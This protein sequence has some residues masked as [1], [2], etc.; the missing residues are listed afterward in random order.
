MEE[1]TGAQV[2]V[3]GNHEIIIE[4]KARDREQ[5]INRFAGSAN[6]K[7]FI[8]PKFRQRIISNCNQLAIPSE[9]LS[10]PKQIVPDVYIKKVA[11]LTLLYDNFIPS[12][13]NQVLER[14]IQ[15]FEAS[16]DPK[17]PPNTI[18]ALGRDAEGVYA[19]VVTPSQ[20]YLGKYFA[21]I[22]DARTL[23]PPPPE[24]LHIIS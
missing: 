22:W 15:I 12:T 19:A 9:R 3:R 1:V 14:L 5:A 8:N 4:S 23:L 18:F 16:P 10:L 20:T 11:D 24:K 6:E 2:I 17:L 7:I 13:A 21:V